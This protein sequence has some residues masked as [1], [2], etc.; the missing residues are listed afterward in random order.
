M[1]PTYNTIDRMYIISGMFLR[2]E[3]KNYKSIHGVFQMFSLSQPAEV[4]IVSK[5]A[6]W[7]TRVYYLI[8]MKYV[9]INY[10]FG[11]GATYILTF[12]LYLHFENTKKQ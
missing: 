7:E 5:L 4:Q 10:T 9:L 1:K 8:W 3:T 12:V 2:R 11:M 6:I